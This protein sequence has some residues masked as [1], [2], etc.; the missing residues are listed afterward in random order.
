MFSSLLGVWQAVPY[1]FADLWGLLNEPEGE[2][3]S[4]G[5]RVDTRLPT[6]R[7]Y[8]AAMTLLPMTGLF[9][10]FGEIQ[11]FY[12]VV[13]AWF[14]PVLALALLLLNGRSSWVGK[15]YCNQPLTMAAL[16]GVLLFFAWIAWRSL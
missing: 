7:G 8:L 12:A 11:K 9:R 15:S 5:T 4:A 16:M 6:Y 13:G 1:L 3:S 14:F 2:A 10:G